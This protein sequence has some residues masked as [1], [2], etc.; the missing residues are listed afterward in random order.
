M[1]LYYGVEVLVLLLV[2][3]FLLHPFANFLVEHGLPKP[4]VSRRSVTLG[5]KKWFS[6]P[7]NHLTRVSSTLSGQMMQISI[8][9]VEGY[10]L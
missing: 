10:S 2:D 6:A 9:F 7:L 5:E 3:K 1:W 8:V 4:H